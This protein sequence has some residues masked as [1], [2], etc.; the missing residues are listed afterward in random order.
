[1]V[2]SQGQVV[3]V[4]SIGGRT[5]VGAQVDIWTVANVPHR[6]LLTDRHGALEPSLAVEDRYIQLYGTK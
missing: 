4:R 2:G 6:A 3:E 1:M 5:L